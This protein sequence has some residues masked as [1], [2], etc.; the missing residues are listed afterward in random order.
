M[1]KL[2]RSHG[3]DIQ[4]PSPAQIDAALEDI[5]DDNGSFLILAT[6]RGFIQ[7]ALAA[8]GVFHLEYKLEGSDTLYQMRNDSLSAE[9]VAEVFERFQE[10]HLDWSSRYSWSQESLEGGGRLG[11]I[12][13]L[14]LLVLTAVATW[15]V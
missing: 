9:E 11:C 8:D 12:G 7:T 14:L 6:E 10:N 3:S 4:D 13:A 1:P 5:E 15:T 2:E